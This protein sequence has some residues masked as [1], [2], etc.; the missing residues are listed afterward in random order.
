MIALPHNALDIALQH[1]LNA[2][3]LAG[4]VFADAFEPLDE[5]DRRIEFPVP[6]DQAFDPQ[7]FV[8][9]RLAVSEG[10]AGLISAR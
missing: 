8:G 10:S 4:E 9:L 1:L 3:R 7:R 2:A 5:I 6:Y